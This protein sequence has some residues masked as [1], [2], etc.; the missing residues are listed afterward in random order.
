LDIVSEDDAVEEARL[1]LQDAVEL[2]FGYASEE[3]MRRRTGAERY[4][5]PMECTIA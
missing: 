5:V 4:I 2:F 1:M 3:G